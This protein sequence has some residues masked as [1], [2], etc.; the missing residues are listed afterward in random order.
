MIGYLPSQLVSFA[1][2]LNHQQKWDNMAE[3]TREPIFWQAAKAKD[4]KE[5]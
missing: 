5:S 3:L 2:F 1:V 4:S